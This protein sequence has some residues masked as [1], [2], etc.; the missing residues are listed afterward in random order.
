MT[1]QIV[2]ISEAAPAHL[3]SEAKKL[4]RDVS[5]DYSIDDAAGQALLREACECLDALRECQQ[6][7]AEDGRVTRGSRKQVRP[8]PLI[9]AELEYRRQMLACFRSLNLDLTPEP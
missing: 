3:S 4:W 5:R 8:H 2:P 6:A 1:A 7:I 9:R